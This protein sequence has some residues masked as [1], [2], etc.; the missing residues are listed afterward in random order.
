MNSFVL[1]P[2]VLVETLVLLNPPR[3][4]TAETLPP[5]SPFGTDCLLYAV[6][7]IYTAHFAYLQSMA[8]AGEV[9]Q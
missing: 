2:L 7:G 4:E 6:W 9:L 8:M 5:P 3:K 1:S